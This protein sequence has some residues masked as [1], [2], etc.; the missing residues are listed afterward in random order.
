[1][2][3]A[4]IKRP[5]SLCFAVLALSAVAG[6]GQ[7]PPPV[8]TAAVELVRIDVIVLDRDG[9]PVTGLTKDDFT[10]EENAQAQAIE[11]FE[12]VVVRARPAAA[13]AEPPRLSVGR[14][15]APGEGRFLFVFFDDRHVTPPAAERVRAA[16]RRF[17]DNDLREGDW[18]TLMAPVQS[19][20]WTARNR[21]EYAQLAAV[22]DRLKGQYARDPL[23]TGMSDWEAMRI[24]QLG[25]SGLA[26]PSVP[27]AGGDPSAKGRSSSDTAARGGEG[28]T[29]VGSQDLTFLAEEVYAQARNGLEATLGG[30]RQALDSLVPLRGRKSLVLV[31]EGFILQPGMAGYAELVDVARRANVAIHFLDPRGLEAAFGAVSQQPPGPGWATERAIEEAGADD[32][33]DATGGRAIPTNDLTEGLRR[34]TSESEV[35]YLLGYQPR[36]TEQGERKVKVR[37]RRDGLNVRA[38]SRYYVGEAER[39]GA[40]REKERKKDETAGRTPEEKAAMRAVGDTND[41]PLRLS[42]LFFDNNGRG[43]VT[44]M[45]PVEIR[46]PVAAPGKAKF[47]TVAEARPGDGGKAMRD[48]FET[49]LNLRPGAETILSR[50][51]YMPPGVWQI[52]VLVRELTTGKVGTAL[53]TFDVPSP[54]AFRIASPILTTEME[55]T[56]GRDRPRVVLGRTFRSGQLLY[57]QY[58]VHGAAGDP[59]TRLPVVTA[60]WELRRGEEVVRAAEPTPIRPDWD[61]RLSRLLGVS[62]EGLEIGDYELALRVTDTIGAR[63][64]VAREPFTVAP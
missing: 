38:R 64:A 42:A 41:L 39:A 12:A 32:L 2:K 3:E 56:D 30:L 29:S 59:K 50:H 28:R 40:R 13:A 55:K 45:Y 5:L 35:Y 26:S 21:W 27:S 14:I 47:R 57:V 15:R 23:R 49:E 46:V 9:R 6:H 60:G 16:L 18:L 43:Q 7:A 11:S 17:V 1:V 22:V 52:R 48:E 34:V 61:G 19:L 31:S 33:A 63:E 24:V 62:L 58:Q 37:V 8:F 10:V 36:R 20:W 54:E 51:W 4:L 53:H 44:T 25:I